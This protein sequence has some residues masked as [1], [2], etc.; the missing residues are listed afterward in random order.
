MKSYILK[1]A[2]LKDLARSFFLKSAIEEADKRDPVD[3][4][5]D[6]QVLLKFCQLKLEEA[7]IKA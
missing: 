6:A 4:E 2:I 3:A 1:E 7:G 5:M